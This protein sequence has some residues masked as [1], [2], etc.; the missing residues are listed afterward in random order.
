MTIDR[1]LDDRGFLLRFGNAFDQHLVRHQVDHAIV[2]GADDVDGRVVGEFATAGDAF[3]PHDLANAQLAARVAVEPQFGVDLLAFEHVRIQ[4]EIAEPIERALRGHAIGGQILEQRERRRLPGAALDSVG[5]AEEHGVRSQQRIA[6][7]GVR[8]GVGLAGVEEDE[9]A[10]EARRVLSPEVVRAQR[11]KLVFA[12]DHVSGV[13]TELRELQQ[14]RGIRV[15]V[16]RQDG[17]D[18]AIRVAHLPRRVP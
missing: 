7:L 10:V 9:F 15:D 3:E 1:E 5:P 14:V 4:L 6:E 8:V 18:A 13:Q 17:R 11:E 12:A 16:A 2:R